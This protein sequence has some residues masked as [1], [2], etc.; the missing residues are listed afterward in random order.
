MKITLVL[1]QRFLKL[2]NWKRIYKA[3]VLNINENGSLHVKCQ[4]G[5]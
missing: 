2:Q 4:D 1:V 5:K 3:E